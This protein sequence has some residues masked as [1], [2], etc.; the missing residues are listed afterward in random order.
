MIQSKVELVECINADKSRNIVNCS[1]LYLFVEPLLA[2]FGIVRESY[3]VRRYLRTLR[4]L[5][6]FTNINR[7]GKQAVLYNEVDTSL[8]QIPYLHTSEHCRQRAV[9]STFSR[10]GA[11]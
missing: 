3:Y 6:Y 5:E 8:Q 2:L 11:A 10:R 1:K 7:G 9:H 4:K